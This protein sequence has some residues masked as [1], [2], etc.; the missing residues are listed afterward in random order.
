MVSMWGFKQYTLHKWSQRYIEETE[1]Q[2]NINRRAYGTCAWV[3]V[4]VV[5][6]VH[7]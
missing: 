1:K 6:W 7:L 3:R 5:G 4:G 2:Q